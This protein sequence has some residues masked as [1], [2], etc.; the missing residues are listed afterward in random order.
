MTKVFCPTVFAIDGH[1]FT[2][3]QFRVLPHFR[4][5]DIILGLLAL[6]KLKVACSYFTTSLWRAHRV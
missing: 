1:E 2:D 5:S 6:K 3:L 4:D